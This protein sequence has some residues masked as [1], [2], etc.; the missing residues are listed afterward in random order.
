[1]F[2]DDDLIRIALSLYRSKARFNATYSKASN[3]ALFDVDT[4][5][6]DFVY[7]RLIVVLNKDVAR[8]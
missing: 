7:Y 2:R 5:F 6:Y 8:F 3:A 4:T 1:M